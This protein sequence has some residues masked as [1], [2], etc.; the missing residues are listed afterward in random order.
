MGSNLQKSKQCELK[1][2]NQTYN[3]HLESIEFNVQ[4]IEV[5]NEIE[6]EINVKLFAAN[7]AKNMGVYRSN[8]LAN[9]PKAKEEDN[10][11]KSICTQDSHR[12]L[13]M[14]SMN[15]SWANSSPSL[16]ANP[17][18]FEEQK[19]RGKT[20]QFDRFM[21]FPCK[22]HKKQHLSSNDVSLFLYLK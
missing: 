20:Q 3:E 4:E 1:K 6:T 5:P 16:K 11:S 12:P 15:T 18:E 10:S 17:L 19:N 9:Y 13:K 2:T 22:S 21:I 8:T 14:S 7:R